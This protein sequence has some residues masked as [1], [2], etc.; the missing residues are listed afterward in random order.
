MLQYEGF[1]YDL[2][3]LFQFEMLKKIIEALAKRQFEIDKKL[4]IINN[5]ATSHFESLLNNQSLTNP[6]DPS[7]VDTPINPEDYNSRICLL[8]NKLKNLPVIETWLKALDQKTASNIQTLSFLQSDLS[9]I[10]DRLNS[11]EFSSNNNS[12]PYE[13]LPLD[14]AENDVNVKYISNDN[15]SLDKDTLVVLENKVFKKFNLID[16]KFKQIDNNIKR[17]QNDIKKN[18][19]LINNNSN[20]INELTLMLSE[21]K[22]HFDDF[23]KNNAIKMEELR[24]TLENQYN[25]KLDTFIKETNEQFTQLQEN[26]NTNYSNLNDMCTTLSNK[27]KETTA[28]TNSINNKVKELETNIPIMITNLGIKRIENKL[29]NLANEIQTK[30]SNEDFENQSKTI[31]ELTSI[32]TSLTSFKQ[33]QDELN[34]KRGQEITA[35]K[36][37]IETLN[38]IIGL[39]QTENSNIKSQNNSLNSKGHLDINALNDS[40]KNLNI[41]I[42]QLQKESD[43]YRRNFTDILPLM[44]KLASITDLKNLEDVLKAMLEEYKLMGYKRF[45]DKTEM[46]KSLKLLDTQIKHLIAEYIKKHDKGENWMIASKPVGGFKCAS[47]ESYIGELNNKWEYLPWNK[48]PT[49]DYVDKSYRMGNGFSRMLQKL[50]L[51][52]R[53]SDEI[54]TGNIGELSFDEGS[55][56]EKDRNLSSGRVKEKRKGM[57]GLPKIKTM[58][59]LDGANV[60]HTSSMNE[61][62]TISKKNIEENETGNNNANTIHVSNKIVKKAISKQKEPRL[63]KIMR[64]AKINTGNNFYGNIGIHNRSGSAGNSRDKIIIEI[65]Q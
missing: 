50:N 21:L 45:A 60:E 28:L 35:I 31:N 39:L 22:N 33:R 64:K 2:N 53:R 26:I 65:G 52:V 3:S 7:R 23:L 27:Q 47:C 16:T 8:E 41:H 62:Q 5:P 38:N 58:Q 43:E 10:N 37:K 19:A 40:I 49:R 25:A 18:T 34:E 46:H 44:G 48:Y 56:G 29:S 42:D 36:T 63:V 17:M 51:D 20:D 54:N 4:S 1:T 14:E 15:N 32:L 13:N 59:C 11:G 24:H 6:D 9:N 30:S 57:K 55:C 61:Q 12:N